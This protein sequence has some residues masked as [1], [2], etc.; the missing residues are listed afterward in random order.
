MFL[1]LHNRKTQLFCVRYVANGKNTF[2][3]EKIELGKDKSI[4]FLLR[5]ANRQKI[6]YKKEIV[7]C[8][9]WFTCLLLNVNYPW[10][11]AG[12]I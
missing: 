3:G 8:R 2:G 10:G 1:I 5:T 4:K 11:T 6:F 9:D 7:K 12:Q